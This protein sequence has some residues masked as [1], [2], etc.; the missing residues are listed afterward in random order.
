VLH[1]LAPNRA[2]NLAAQ[3]AVEASN[4]VDR[5]AECWLAGLQNLGDFDIDF[6][7]NSGQFCIVRIGHAKYVL[8][9]RPIGAL[10]RIDARRRFTGWNKPQIF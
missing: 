7:A 9:Q 8:H 2:R 4:R 1:G 5:I 10:P 3:E 6:A